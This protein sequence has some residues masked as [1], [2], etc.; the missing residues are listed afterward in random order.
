MAVTDLDDMWFT[1]NIR[2]DML[3]GLGI[4]DELLVRVPAL[5]NAVYRTKVSYMSVL[6][7]YATWRATQDTGGYDA[8]TFEV[9]SIPEEKIGGL[10]PGMTAIVAYGESVR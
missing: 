5:G 8:R 4:G 1:F 2:E 9:R 10:L 6:Q 7:S 3:H